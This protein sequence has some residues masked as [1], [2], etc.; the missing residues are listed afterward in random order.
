MREQTHLGIRPQL[1]QHTKSSHFLE[2]VRRCLIACR[3]LL[4]GP[5]LRRQDSRG[6]S[7]A[8][9]VPGPFAP[10]RRHLHK[11]GHG[12]AG[13][14]RSP[15]SG[16]NHRHHGR[17]RRRIRVGFTFQP[18]AVSA[19]CAPT[20]D[21]YHIYSY[22]IAPTKELLLLYATIPAVRHVEQMAYLT[23]RKAHVNIRAS[24]LAR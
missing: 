7:N 17:L 14:P 13:R 18:A 21:R 20:K 4:G 3:R 11:P 10:F 5:E 22:L 9:L 23:L 6:H 19:A 16:N 8:P 24:S 15:A 2:C 1:E 12:A